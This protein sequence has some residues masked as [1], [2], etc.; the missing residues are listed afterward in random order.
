[1]AVEET[2]FADAANDAEVLQVGV[3]TPTSV[4]ISKLVGAVTVTAPVK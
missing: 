4:E 1:M 2:V 3:A